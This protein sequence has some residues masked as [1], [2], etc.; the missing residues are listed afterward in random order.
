MYVPPAA[1]RD[2]E[3]KMHD[4]T[5]KGLSRAAMRALLKSAEEHRRYVRNREDLLKSGHVTARD[6]MMAWVLKDGWYDHIIR[7]FHQHPEYDPPEDPAA[8]RGRPVA[9]RARRALPAAGGRRR[10]LPLA[11]RQVLNICF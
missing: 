11:R 7:Y 5:E 6:F 8:G 2:Q 10:E 3:Q 4:L 1:A 9:Q